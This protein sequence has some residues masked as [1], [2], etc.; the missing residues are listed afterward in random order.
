MKVL[1]L[2]ELAPNVVPSQEEK[3][4]TKIKVHAGLRRV[5]ETFGDIELIEY[6]SQ[7]WLL[8]Q[9]MALGGDVELLDPK[10]RGALLE[11]IQASK[12]LYL[13]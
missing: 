12:N 9:V 10:L 13:G 8:G 5:R 11:R 1:D 7:D 2:Q 4:G 3:L 6:H